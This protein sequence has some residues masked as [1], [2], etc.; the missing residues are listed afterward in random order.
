MDSLQ[1]SVNS[2]AKTQGWT[3]FINPFFAAFPAILNPAAGAVTLG[4]NAGVATANNPAVKE[5][6]RDIG[7]A[8]QDFG[9]KVVS[10][11]GNLI[12][13]VGEAVGSAAKGVGDFA[14]SGLTRVAVIGVVGLI[15]FVVVTKV[16]GKVTD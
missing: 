1:T 11:P 10:V 3:S 7:D 8:V 13:G 9:E 14:L 4:M 6:V 16:I 2:T 12:K 15:G 5:K